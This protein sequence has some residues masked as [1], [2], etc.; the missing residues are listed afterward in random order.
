MPIT[1]A[2]YRLLNEGIS[3]HETLKD[4]MTRPSGFEN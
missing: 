3:V 2:V 4:L 1:E